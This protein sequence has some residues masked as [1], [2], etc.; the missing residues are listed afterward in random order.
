MVVIIIRTIVTGLAPRT[1]YSFRLCA[2][3]SE[4]NSAFTQSVSFST[5]LGISVPPMLLK[6]QCKPASESI[7][8]QWI[9]DEYFADMIDIYEIK[10][11][12]ESFIQEIQAKD[13]SLRVQNLLPGTAYE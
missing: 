8:I 3:N 7:W 1:S 13:T 11:T 12:Y 2:H 5:I 9:C 10:V 4:G 6:D